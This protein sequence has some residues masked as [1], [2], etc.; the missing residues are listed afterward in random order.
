MGVNVR[1]IGLENV[2]SMTR[3]AKNPTPEGRGFKSL[4]IPL[5][6]LDKDSDWNIFNLFNRRTN[7]MNS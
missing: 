4:M 6:L 5:I 2:V 1:T 7:L 3:K